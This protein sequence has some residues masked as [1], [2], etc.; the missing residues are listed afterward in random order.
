MDSRKQKFLKG[1]IKKGLYYDSVTLM[2]ATRDTRQ[3]EGVLDA[4]VVMATKENLAILENANMLPDNLGAASDNDLIIVID[5][6]SE[7]HAN[8]AMQHLDKVFQGMNKKKDEGIMHVPKSLDAALQNMPDANIVLISLAGKYATEEARKAIENGLHVMLFSDNISIEDELLLKRA[9]H[10]K[11]LLMMGPDCGTAIINGVPLGFANAINRGTIGLIGA[12]GTGLQEV[13]S[14]ISRAGAGVSQVI[15]TGGRDLHRDIGGIMFLDALDALSNDENTDVIGL[16]SK[17]PHPEVMPKILGALNNISKPAV[18]M[19]IGAEKNIPDAANIYSTATLEEAALLCVALSKKKNPETATNEL[20]K[21][22]NDLLSQAKFISKNIKGKYIRGLFSGGTLC[23][24]AQLILN[25]NKIMSYSN[26]P[27]DKAYW[28]NDVWK[29]KYHTLI[30]MGTDEFTAGRPH[31]MIDFSLRNKRIIE[32]A[33]DKEV[34]IILFDVVLGY[35]ANPNPA[36]ELVPAIETARKTSPHI[37]FVCSITGTDKDPQNYG[38]VFKKLQQAGVHVLP[39]ISAAAQ[40][41][42]YAL[43]SASTRNS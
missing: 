16:I 36:R 23:F 19:F 38:K 4:S 37:Q 27:L 18:A 6:E 11:G 32:E 33:H 8:A 35:G 31:P 25:N 40:F 43:Q 13:G 2:L 30:D 34:A 1:T 39:S 17:P 12:S 15:G 7:K 29:S 10:A 24:E 42:S 20:Q 22:S 3:M 5:A 26:A 14:I 9:A 41:C 21:H 28:L